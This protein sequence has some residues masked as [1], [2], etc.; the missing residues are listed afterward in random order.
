MTVLLII[1]IV[2][3]VAGVTIG[4]VLILKNSSEQ[5]PVKKPPKKLDDYRQTY[6]TICDFEEE[7]FTDPKSGAQRIGY[8]P[9][10]EYVYNGTRYTHVVTKLKPARR[11]LGRQQKVV[12]HVKN[13]EEV[14][15]R[16]SE[17]PV[18]IAGVGVLM[19]V[20]GMIL[21]IKEIS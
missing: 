16:P 14:L 1:M 20:A 8:H 13:P 21:L 12:F 6:G 19:V 15:E 7:T 5:D 11:G 17:L 9:V 10:V 3:V 4:A 18:L 2:A